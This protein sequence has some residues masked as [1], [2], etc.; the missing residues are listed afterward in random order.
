M[1]VRTKFEEIQECK[2]LL[3]LRNLQLRLKDVKALEQKIIISLIYVMFLLH[4]TAV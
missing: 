1:N 2:T 3:D 4:T